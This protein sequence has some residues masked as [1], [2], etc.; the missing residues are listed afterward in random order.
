VKII[1][2]LGIVALK[3]GREDEARKFFFTA[4]EIEPEDPVSRKFLE[5]MGQ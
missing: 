5:E 1:S 2:N 4:L 3:T